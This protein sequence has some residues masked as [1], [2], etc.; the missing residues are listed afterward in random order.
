[1]SGLLLL[2]A[3]GAID[4]PRGRARF[5][6]SIIAVLLIVPERISSLAALKSD[7]SITI[8]TTLARLARCLLS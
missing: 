7:R 8:T 3:V 1:M 4:P 2:T 6:L 5:V